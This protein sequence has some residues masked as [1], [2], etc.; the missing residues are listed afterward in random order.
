MLDYGNYGKTF[1]HSC[2][3]IIRDLLPEIGIPHKNQVNGV[4]CWFLWA[5]PGEDISAGVDCWITLP[6]CGEVAVDFTVIS[7]R[8]EELLKQ[9]VQTA[10]DRGIIPVVLE[11][12][13]LQAAQNGSSRAIEEF[14]QEIRLQIPLKLRGLNGNRMTRER[15]AAM[16]VKRRAAS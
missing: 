1:G 10:L 2:E 11:Q 7:P 8:N 15:A 16:K 12:R 13:M 9:K 4:G 14:S 6:E 5:T 3:E